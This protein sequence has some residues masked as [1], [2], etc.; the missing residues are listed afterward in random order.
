ML[1]G[2]SG[3]ILASVA[4]PVV[5]ERMCYAPTAKGDWTIAIYRLAE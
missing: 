2:R 3:W 1:S 4:R 5:T